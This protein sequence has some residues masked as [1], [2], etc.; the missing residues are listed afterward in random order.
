MKN[1]ANKIDK[2][3][4]EDNNLS[5]QLKAQLNKKKEILSNNK[6]VKK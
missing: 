4:K 3:L 6:T 5:P 1:M 2:L